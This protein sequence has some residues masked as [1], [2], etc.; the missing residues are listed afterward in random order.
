MLAFMTDAT[1]ARSRREE[2]ADATRAALLATALEMFTTEGYPAVGIEAIARAAR[3]TR[4]ALYHHFA[5]KKALFEALVI[6]L[7]ADAVEK[8][9]ARAK[10]ATTAQ[11][12]MRAGS[13]AFLDA[14]MEPSYRRLVIEEAPAVLGTVRCREIEEAHAFGLLIAAISAQQASGAFKTDNA[15]LAARMVGT[16]MC[17]A[18]LLLGDAK[19]PAEM[20]RQVV[21]T[22]ERVLAAFEGA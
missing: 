4:G 17:E 14:C 18:A 19:R 12:R 22:V 7:Q 15:Y 3:V 6:Q 20:K 2:Y 8:I 21:A 1:P 5:D 16:M 9:K 11:E 10:R 13:L